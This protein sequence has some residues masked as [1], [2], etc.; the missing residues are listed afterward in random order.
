MKTKIKW[1]VIGIVLLIS[2]QFFFAIYFNLLG[3]GGTNTS[4]DKTERIWSHPEMM[5]IPI[6]A[7]PL[8]EEFIFRFLLYRKNLREPYGTITAVISSILFGLV[9]G[10]SLSLTVPL[11]LNGLIYCLVYKKG[12]SIWV[13]MITHGLYNAMI[14]GILTLTHIIKI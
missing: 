6:L 7:A 9:H 8:I 1:I 11:I 14:L 10:Q 12:D 3:I 5:L 13:S 2:I 4:I